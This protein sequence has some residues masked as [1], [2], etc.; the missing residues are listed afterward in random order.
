MVPEDK[1]GSRTTVRYLELEFD[2]SLP[3]EI[4]SLRNLRSRP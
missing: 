3:S 1:K 2:A 4:F